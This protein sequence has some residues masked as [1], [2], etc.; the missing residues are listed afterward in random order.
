[1]FGL[2]GIFTEV[3]E[4]VVFRVVPDLANDAT[5]MIRGVGGHRVLSGYR[6]QPPVSEEMLV[7]LLIRTSAM[8]EDLAGSSS[9]WT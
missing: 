6:G 5:A 8:A 9:P 1:M 2:G 4:D 3:F 7:D